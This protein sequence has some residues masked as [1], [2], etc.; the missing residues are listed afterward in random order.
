MYKKK[1]VVFLYFQ[2]KKEIQREK[3]IGKKYEQEK[4]ETL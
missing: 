1:G 3:E 4:R 2:L